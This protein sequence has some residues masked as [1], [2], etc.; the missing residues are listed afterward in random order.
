[1][2][3]LDLDCVFGPRWKILI[4]HV[5]LATCHSSK[6]HADVRLL[7]IARNASLGI[8]VASEIVGQEAAAIWTIRVSG[9]CG[10]CSVPGAGS[11]RALEMLAAA[12]FKKDA[13][14]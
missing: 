14:L 6:C 9:A 3:R 4:V 1:L 13:I 11:K 10:A 2:N 5:L 8:E 7:S 12:D